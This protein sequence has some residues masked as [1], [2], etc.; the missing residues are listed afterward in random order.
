MNLLSEEQIDVG[1]ERAMVLRAQ[2][3]D[4]GAM[5]ELM[6]IHQPWV[7]NIVLRMVP[8][9]HEAEDLCQEIMLK[10]FLSLRSFEGKSRFRTWLYRISVNHVLTMR[11]SACERNTR[12]YYRRAADGDLWDRQLDMEI[13]DPATI[14]NDLA[15]IVQ[16]IRI[17]CLMGMLLC[18]NRKQRIVFILGDILAVGSRAGGEIVGISEGG[19][20][21]ILSRSRR[22]LSNFLYDRC[23]LF[24]PERPCT[25]ERSI[26]VN[27][28]SGYVDPLNLVFRSNDTPAIR[29]LISGAQRKLDRIEFSKCRELYREQA[30]QQSPDFSRKV[31]EILGSKDFQDLLD[32]LPTKG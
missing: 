31:L 13:A 12:E 30:L 2:K 17:K 29:E 27:L 22:K 20:R 14:P 19:Y 11:E 4:P 5:E 26:G 32:T 9:F 15:L 18:L 16:E 7:F 1:E 6:R 28:K 8:N 10:A 21:Q 25:C 3:G 23:S 24:N